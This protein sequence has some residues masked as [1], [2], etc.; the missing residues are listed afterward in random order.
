LYCCFAVVPLHAQ[1]QGSWKI[2][3]T[4]MTTTHRASTGG[5]ND[6][7]SA[8]L[9]RVYEDTTSTAIV[10]GSMFLFDSAN[11]CGLYAAQITLSAGSGFEKGKT[12]HV[13]IEATDVDSIVDA[14]VLGPLQIEADVSV[15]SIEVRGATGL[16]TI[17]KN[18]SGQSVD[19]VLK[20]N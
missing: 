3:Y 10:T 5:C 6:A 20:K 17:R 1:Y 2:N 18:I 16:Y 15:N 4:F 7:F 19:F 14:K 11:T 9:Y 12:Y 8:P 13:Y